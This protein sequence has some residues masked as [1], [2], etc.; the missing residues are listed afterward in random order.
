MLTIKLKGEI[1]K[2]S[3]HCKLAECVSNDTLRPV[4][5]GALFDGKILTATDG[6]MLVQIKVQDADEDTP[7][8]IPAVIL[9]KSTVKAKGDDKYNPQAKITI[10][11]NTAETNSGTS[12][13]SEKIIDANYPDKDKVIKEAEIVKNE[14]DMIFAINAEFLYKL[15]KAIGSKEI[16]ISVRQDNNVIYVIPTGSE[17]IEEEPFGILA[18]VK[19]D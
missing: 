15:A 3:K 1:M 9:K 6:H 2:F 10:R 7:G 14:P 13:L 12:F 19:N 16:K 8:I 5:Q 11:D 4:L 18:K 17:P